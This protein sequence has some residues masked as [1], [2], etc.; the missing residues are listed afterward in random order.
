MSLNY[1][2]ISLYTSQTKLM[3]SGQSR[4]KAPV[5]QCPK[6]YDPEKF[7][8]I[9]T[10]FD[11]LDK[12]SNLGV[13]S[14]EL[15]SIAKLHVKNCKTQLEKRL[16]AEKESLERQLVEIEEKC[17][18]DIEKVRFEAATAK[19]SARQQSKYAQANIQSKIDKYA[20]LDEDGQ[21]NAFMKVLMARDESHIDFWTFFEY[22]KSRTDDI[23]NIEEE[24]SDDE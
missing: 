16:N 9:C 3:G 17:A 2:G 4:M 11:K 24:S 10:L 21:E 19:Q 23:E 22:M 13:S 6:D 15:T 1:Y 7:Q 14:D 5:L 18:Q 20:G 12:D 8:K